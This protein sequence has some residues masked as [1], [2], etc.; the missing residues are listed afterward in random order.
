MNPI[1]AILHNT[2]LIKTAKVMLLT[3][4]ELVTNTNWLPCPSSTSM[5]PVKI[6]WNKTYSEPSIFGIMH[7]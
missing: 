6:R 1:T 5:Y 4:D 2:M 7:K 3:D